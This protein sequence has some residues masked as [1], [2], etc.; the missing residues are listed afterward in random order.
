MHPIQPF[1]L[2][3]G[4]GRGQR[5]CL[6]HAARPGVPARGRVL[7]VHAFAEELNK[8][9]RMSALQARALA[10][11]GY[12][13]LQIDLLGCGDSSGEFSDASWQDWLDD[14]LSAQ[15]WLSARAQGPLWLW[16]QRAGCLLAN[17]LAERLDEPCQLLYW[18][19]PASGKLLLQQFLRLKLAA[20]LMDGG[21]AG[22]MQAL[23]AEI[24][25]GAT[26]EI[27]G[28]GLSATLA[29]ALEQAS[30]Q[31]PGRP[32]RAHWLELGAQAEPALLPALSTLAER[33]RAAGCELQTHAL[34]GPAFW[35]TSEIEEAPA[36]IAA[37]L[38]AM[39]GTL[40]EQVA[41]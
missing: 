4:T 35:Q 16:G 1:F 37:S 28:Y 13:V 14:L 29:T 5:F 10:E 17:A 26:V 24:A 20:G 39:R 41:A 25:T 11:A 7:H 3:P 12:A 34:Q 19:P 9:R 15:A 30:L 33:W 6:F 32:C 31:P 21:A 36:L 23:K 18:Q 22:A 8:S 27:A 38:D 40:A 2:E